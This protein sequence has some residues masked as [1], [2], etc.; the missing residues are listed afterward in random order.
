MDYSGDRLACAIIDKDMPWLVTKW[1]NIEGMRC[2]GDRRYSYSAR[3]EQDM[4]MFYGANAA[5]II[6]DA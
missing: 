6:V 3:G 1:A 4:S 2:A 5:V